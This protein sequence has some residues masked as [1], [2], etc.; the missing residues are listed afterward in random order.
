MNLLCFF[1]VIMACLS[2]R[3]GGRWGWWVFLA[4]LVSD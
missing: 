3:D 2:A 4:L 1:F